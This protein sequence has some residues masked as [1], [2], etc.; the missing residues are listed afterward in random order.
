M[1]R[2]YTLPFL[3]QLPWSPLYVHFAAKNSPLQR[4]WRIIWALLQ[5]HI[6]FLSVLLARASSSLLNCLERY[7]KV[8]FSCTCTDR[9]LYQHH[10]KKHAVSQQPPNGV[11]PSTARIVQ[12]RSQIPIP[13]Q[14]QLLLER[15]CFSC[16]ICGKK[17][18]NEQALKCHEESGTKAHKKFKCSSCKG[19]YMTQERLDAVSLFVSECFVVISRVSFSIA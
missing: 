12:P 7:L 5:G 15:P 3:R 14:K 11:P 13:S 18:A 8:A 4:D 16:K 1:R 10:V 19:A 2:I 6:A 17:M 9:R